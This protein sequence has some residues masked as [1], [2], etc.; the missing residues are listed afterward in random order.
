MASSSGKLSTEVLSALSLMLCL[1]V[2]AG[3]LLGPCP[4]RHTPEC[5]V[6]RFPVGSYCLSFQMFLAH[7]MQG[8][9]GK[10]P[11][12]VYTSS[13]V[14]TLGFVELFCFDRTVTSQNLLL[15]KNICRTFF[16]SLFLYF[17]F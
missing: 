1:H 10:A 15:T 16:P 5:D 14:V 2:S 8:S 9:V 4:N 3:S 7:S 6:P 11:K 17:N 12:C 13:V